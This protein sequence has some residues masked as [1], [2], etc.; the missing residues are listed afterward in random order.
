MKATM[1]DRLIS[2][3]SGVEPVSM[4]TKKKKTAPTRT[5]TPSPAFDR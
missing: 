1:N 5:G 2:T 4:H 3:I